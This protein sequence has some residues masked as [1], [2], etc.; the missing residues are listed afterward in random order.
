VRRTADE[1]VRRIED[2][3]A[4]TLATRL[5]EQKIECEPPGR[6]RHQVDRALLLNRARRGLVVES[7]VEV[8]DDAKAL[9]GLSGS[10]DEFDL[11]ACP[12]AHP[13]HER[14]GDRDQHWVLRAGGGAHED[15]GHRHE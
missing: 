7:L 6:S 11:E 13:S 4:V 5:V 3:D 9:Q 14:P 10:I 1:D 8:V 15:R 12:L 2:L